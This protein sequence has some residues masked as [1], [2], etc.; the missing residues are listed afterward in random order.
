MLEIINVANSILGWDA[1]NTHVNTLDKVIEKGA[2]FVVSIKSNQDYL[3][4]DIETAFQYLD[5]NRYKGEVYHSSR[6]SDEHG[7]I[8][9]KVIDILDATESLTKEMRKKW[10]HVRSV[11]RVRTKRIQKISGIES[12]I[13]ACYFISSIAPDGTDESFA[14]TM[15]DIILKKWGIES[16]HWVIDVVFDQDRLPL[17]NQ[18]YIAN[19]TYFTKMSV[20]VLSFIRGNAPLVYK[21]PQ[22]FNTLQIYSRDPKVAFKFVEAF[23]MNDFNI[24]KENEQ[25][26]FVLGIEDE[27]EEVTTEDVSDFSYVDDYLDDTLL[28]KALKARKLRKIKTK[29]A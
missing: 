9:E 4:E 24:V 6:T 3:Y 8:E 23:F 19:S 18:N 10:R 21:K 13:E 1:I 2:D 5:S 7:R 12:E 29:S 20:N 15:Q 26:R 17:R 25:A 28:A 11:I 16:R 14:R 22:S 27:Y